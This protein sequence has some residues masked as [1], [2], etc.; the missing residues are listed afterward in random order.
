MSWLSYHLPVLGYHRVGAF[1][2]D[3]VPTVSPQTFEWQ[4]RFLA[5]H[6][7]QV[8]SV[9]AVVGFLDRRAP[10]PRRSVVITF[11]DGY[12]ETHQIAWPLLKSFRF[13]ATVFVTPNEVG[14]PGF[15]G[16]G[17]I[18]EMFRDGVTIGSHTM[19][20]TYLPL[21]AEERLHEEIVESKRSLETRLEQPIHYLS[22]PVGGFT[23]LVQ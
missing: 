16:W 7:F 1:H 13:P 12:E 22:Y 9:D 6:R 23:P 17:Q 3:H 15:A 8:F 5:R 2:G 10:F 14:L 18:Q 21:A 20:H 11:D 19:N 4:L